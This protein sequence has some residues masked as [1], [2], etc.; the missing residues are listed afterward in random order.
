MLLKLQHAIENNCIS[1]QQQAHITSVTSGY[2]C[3]Q[4]YRYG[5]QPHWFSSCVHLAF[6]LSFSTQTLQLD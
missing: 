1:C 2:R 3:L 4:A 5:S 6:S